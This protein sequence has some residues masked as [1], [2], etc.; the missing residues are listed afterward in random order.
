MVAGP[1][2][3]EDVA[4]RL[5]LPPARHE[6]L[7]AFRVAVLRPLPQAP[8]DDAV[9]GA[10][11]AT[12][13]AL[14]RAGARVREVAAEDI[15]GD[16]HAFS[17]LFWTLV[18]PVWAQAAAPDPVADAADR[19]HLLEAKLAESAGG[20]FEYARGLTGNGTAFLDAQPRGSATGRPSGASS[21]TGTSSWRPSPRCSALP[22][23][24][25]RTADL[26]AY[27][28]SPPSPG[29]P[30]RPSPP[31]SRPA[32]CRWACRRSGPTSGPHPL[33]FAALLADLRGGF[34]PPPGFGA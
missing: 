2:A 6:R 23:A 15:L 17:Q 12:A 30:P 22:H 29:S 7:A 24:A 27:P 20:G 33:R 18:W 11:A 21:G 5:A 1:E 25:A 14:A 10:L 16:L 13:A 32:G 3:G 34:R 31:G 19:G 8:L 26:H 28:S 9:G 4:W